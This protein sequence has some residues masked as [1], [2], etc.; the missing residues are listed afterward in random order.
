MSKSGKAPREFVKTKSSKGSTKKSRKGMSDTGS[1]RQDNWRTEARALGKE[2]KYLDIYISPLLYKSTEAL[3]HVPVYSISFNPDINGAVMVPNLIPSG[4]DITTRKDNA[5]KL[6]SLY[7]QGM[8]RFP[9]NASDDSREF[10]ENVYT[11]PSPIPSNAR[12]IHSGVIRIAVVYD[13][14]PNGTVQTAAY[15]ANRIFGLDSTAQTPKYLLTGSNTTGAAA[16]DAYQPDAFQNMRGQGRF[17]LLADERIQFGGGGMA[18]GEIIP[19]PANVYGG[20]PPVVH[21]SRYL[22]LGGIA[23]HFSKSEASIDL[24]AIVKGALYVV[25]TW[26]PAIAGG[27]PPVFEGCMRL[28]FDD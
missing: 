20:S 12:T 6:R 3:A 25:Q 7:I 9:C 16:S 17:R 26:T 18:S 11:T 5:I 1:K 19:A 15:M 28:R 23:T 10:T 14:S 13:E 24:S 21:Y 27:V 2:K 22:K 8:W 4:N